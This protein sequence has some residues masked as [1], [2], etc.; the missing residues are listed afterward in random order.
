MVLKFHELE[1]FK[2]INF[3]IAE[4]FLME[5]K[6]HE[7]E[8]QENGRFLLIFETIVDF[9]IFRLKVLQCHFRLGS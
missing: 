1:I 3:K 2:K 5:L 8:Y 4:N 7:L 6:F 9:Y